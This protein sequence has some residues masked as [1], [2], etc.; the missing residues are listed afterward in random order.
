M[1]WKEVVLKAQQLGTTVNSPYSETQRYHA[2]QR[3]H[4]IKET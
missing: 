4:D 1:S 3:F 2:T